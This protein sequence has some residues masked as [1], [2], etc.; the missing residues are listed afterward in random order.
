MSLTGSDYLEIA[1]EFVEVESRNVFIYI[2]FYLPLGLSLQ[3]LLFG[4]WVNV[5]GLGYMF[6]FRIQSW[7]LTRYCLT[8]KQF[9]TDISINTAV[10]SA[11]KREPNLNLTFR[12]YQTILD[13]TSFP[14]FL[15]LRV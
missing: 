6:D 9:Q 14:D 4:F 3:H 5:K 10:A 8:L 13:I 2:F 12:N 1:E 7:M 15:S 11:Q